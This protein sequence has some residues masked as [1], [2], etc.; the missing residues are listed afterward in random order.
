MS[1][2]YPKVTRN[3]ELG[4]PVGPYSNV[5]YVDAVYGSDG[6]DGKRPEKAMLTLLAAYN[7]CTAGQ[8]D[9]VVLISGTSGL[10]L[11]AAFIWAKDYTHLVGMCAP[12]QEGKR[13]R[14]FAAS[15]LAA[16]VFFTI[17]AQGCIFKDFYIFHGP[18]EAAALGNVLVTGERN[19]FENV[20]FAGA[21]HATN[22]IDGAYSL[23]LNGGGESR[24]KHCQFG[25][26]TVDAATG[27]RA[28]ALI[29]GYPPRVVFEDCFFGITA[30]NAGAMI[31][32]A[33]DGAWCIE[34][35]LFKDCIFY[36]C[37]ATAINT[38][39]ELPTV[40]TNNQIVMLV[41]CTRSPGID[42]WE[43]SAKAIVFCGGMPD[44]GAGTSQGDMVVY[45][46]A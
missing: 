2:L 35:M 32:E 20:H 44:Q 9:V 45:T 41:N 15:D 14:I 29:G 18:D 5:Y 43:D 31:V 27:V 16:P 7:K 10:T 46:V 17:S 19:Y 36:N 13:A 38:A 8:H 34:Y 30:S 28:V 26:T 11:D 39:F 42:D 23:G 33:D 37:A 24:F 25:L 4:L 12:V 6:H 22:A 3:F 40:D 21:G 1:S